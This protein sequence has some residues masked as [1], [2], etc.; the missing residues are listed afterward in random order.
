M[1]CDGQALHTLGGAGGLQA[2][3]ANQ[4]MIAQT[5]QDGLHPGL[6]AFSNADG[7]NVQLLHIRV[8]ELLHRH[9]AGDAAVA[10][11]IVGHMEGAVIAEAGVHLHRQPV[12]VVGKARSHRIKGGEG[13]VVAGD[14]S[15]VQQHAG[16]EAHA[17]KA[18]ADIAAAG[19]FRFIHG[20]AAVV[21][22]RGDHFPRGG[23]QGLHRGNI[24]VQDGQRPQGRRRLAFADLVNREHA[25]HNGT[26]FQFIGESCRHY[27]TG[28][29][30]WQS[31]WRRL[32]MLQRNLQLLHIAI[33]PMINAAHIGILLFNCLQ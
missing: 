11:I 5:A 15:A 7:R 30:E 13:I 21:V 28:M 29:Q 18:D 4:F 17:A 1:G 20:A 25:G 10:V 22:Q 33:R 9:R 19:D 23:H 12:R 8:A 14:F 27:T 2:H 3:I 24:L 6:P 31:P 16:T 26:S 32:H